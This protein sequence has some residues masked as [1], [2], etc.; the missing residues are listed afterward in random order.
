MDFPRVALWVAG[1]TMDDRAGARESGFL[2]GTKFKT[3]HYEHE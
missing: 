3:T 1:G 2:L